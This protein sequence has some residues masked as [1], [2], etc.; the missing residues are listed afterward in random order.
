MS[1]QEV[2]AFTRLARS[3]IWSLCF[4]SVMLVEIAL[5]IFKVKELAFALTGSLVGLFTLFV[6]YAPARRDLRRA[7]RDG[8]GLTG[9]MMI[10]VL[11]WYLSALLVSYTSYL[12]PFSAVCFG[13]AV[14][15]APSAGQALLILL[16]ALL[17]AGLLYHH[18]ISNVDMTW[19]LGLHGVVVLTLPR[20][21]TPKRFA[22]LF[23]PSSSAVV[24][25]DVGPDSFTSHLVPIDAE[26]KAQAQQAPSPLSTSVR[27]QRQAEEAAR[28]S[29]TRH[30]AEHV[31][32]SMQIDPR[33][34]PLSPQTAAPAAP[35]APPSQSD[36]RELDLGLST[37]QLQPFEIG[38]QLDELRV[39]SDLRR[40]R[41][42]DFIDSS[43]E[44]LLGY[45][46]RLIS[47]ESA[48]LIWRRSDGDSA[49]VRWRWTLRGGAHTWSPHPF[50]MRDPL[51]ASAL[52]TTGVR[53]L[54]RDEEGWDGALPY[55]VPGAVQAGG[56][57]AVPICAYEGAPP[58]GLLCV[59]RDALTPWTERDRFVAFYVAHKLTIDLDVSHFMKQLVYDSDLSERLLFA[60]QRLHSSRTVSELVRA[61]LDA[62]VVQDSCSW[63]A[64][65]LARP[66]GVQ[67]VGSWAAERAPHISEEVYPLGV[68]YVSESM[69]LGAP[70]DVSGEGLLRLMPTQVPELARL[71]QARVL[72]L[73]DTD[74]ERFGAVVLGV[75]ERALLAPPYINTLELVVREATE[76]LSLINAHDLLRE[77]AMTDG[78]TQLR[79]HRTF[80]LDLEQCLRRADRAGASVGLLLLDIDHFKSIND[81]YGHPFGDAVLRGVAQHLQAAMREGDLVA[82][83][84]GEEFAIALDLSQDEDALVAAE[85]ARAAVEALVFTAERREEVRVT[86]SLGLSFYPQDASTKD[87][88]IDRA[89]QAL[90]Q[91]KRRGRN[92]LVVWR[93]VS[94][95]P[96]LSS[97]M[98]TRHPVSVHMGEEELE[99][100]EAPSGERPRGEL[101][102]I[103]ALITPSRGTP[104]RAHPDEMSIFNTGENELFQSRA[105]AAE[106]RAAPSP[107][108]SSPSSPRA[109][110][111]ALISASYDPTSSGDS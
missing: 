15:A 46:A 62:L 73:V 63:L 64:V 72:P 55:Y 56:M 3:P 2:S 8:Y 102:G 42:V 110:A 58:D 92:R 101:Q 48:V 50:S 60:L 18:P 22:S 93:E 104:R 96:G 23:R 83:Y 105:R 88:L 1:S 80:Q 40:K 98:C 95:E 41:P 31:S 94:G 10:T 11:L 90:Y 54:S 21:L 61:L 29:S 34:S 7:E 75:M 25:E 89:D 100:A 20:F 70:I 57:M 39:S 59:D 67:V 71:A 16:A 37:R 84:G 66:K 38:A 5:M 30:S 17:E 81:T 86:I 91:A 82:R 52:A 77:Q 47:A 51:I 14:S 78:L 28:P 24:P 6:Y 49:V 68:D 36:S 19:H 12:A 13:L 103:N 87:L 74:G 111:S 109:P 26:R 108:P 45:L 85:R 53:C 9:L 32:M 79:N 107:S 4:P 97:G 76:K 65:C 43:C 99:G 44:L 27:P 33:L 106:G 69:R 35:A